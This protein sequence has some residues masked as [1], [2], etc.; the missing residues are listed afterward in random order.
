M[1]EQIKINDNKTVEVPTP[2]DPQ[3]WLALFLFKI[4]KP[5]TNEEKLED[6]KNN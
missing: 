2:A 5:K 1:S 6:L 4:F 3:T